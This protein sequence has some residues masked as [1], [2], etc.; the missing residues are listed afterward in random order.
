M[1]KNIE[2]IVANA[3]TGPQP[4]PWKIRLWRTSKGWSQHDLARE[5]GWGPAG[6]EIVCRIEAWKVQVG[7]VRLANL[8]NALCVPTADLVSSSE[9]LERSRSRFNEWC[10]E[11]R[12][13][14]R[15]FCKRWA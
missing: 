11:G 6:N 15:T 5:L 10:A 2:R 8:A 13:D 4:D 1:A 7:E 14:L 9:L 12:P 3:D